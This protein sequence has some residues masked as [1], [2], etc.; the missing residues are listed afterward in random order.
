[1]EEILQVTFATERL[2]GL[3]LKLLN[4]VCDRRMSCHTLEKSHDTIDGNSF[5][6]QCVFDAQDEKNKMRLITICCGVRHVACGE[7]HPPPA[8]LKSFITTTDSTV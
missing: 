5:D 2:F 3:L 6:V 1:M 4:I 7:N 8:S